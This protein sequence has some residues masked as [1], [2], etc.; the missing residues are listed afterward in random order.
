MCRPQA[1]FRNVSDQRNAIATILKRNGLVFVY[2]VV[3]GMAA[4]GVVK[5]LIVVSD[6]L[7]LPF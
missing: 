3:F 6:K 2:A 4:Y 7:G 1:C 5:L